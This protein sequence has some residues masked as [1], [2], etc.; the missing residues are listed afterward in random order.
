MRKKR[1]KWGPNGNQEIFV[2]NSMWNHIIWTEYIAL[3]ITTNVWKIAKVL[4]VDN[5]R[6][7][8]AGSYNDCWYFDR[9]T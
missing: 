4:F 2:D 1:P 7:K 3:T 5:S 6:I 8:Y 9:A